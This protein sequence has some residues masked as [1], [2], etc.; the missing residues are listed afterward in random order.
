MSTILNTWRRYSPIRASR[1]LE[2]EEI[3]MQVQIKETGAIQTLKITDKNGVE[4]TQDFC[5]TG[6][7]WSDFK[8]DDENDVYTCDQDAFDFW[9]AHIA[10]T[11]KFEEMRSEAQNEY[12]FDAVE[13]LLADALNGVEFNDIPSYGISALE[14]LSQ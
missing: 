6:S 9:V 2:L 13:S 3:K 7:D 8:W 12:G 5:S 10:K 11:E 1:S 4:Y 14:T